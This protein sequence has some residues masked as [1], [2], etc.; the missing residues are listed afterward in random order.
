M[1]NLG[2][3]RTGVD[4]LDH[5]GVDCF[6]RKGTTDLLAESADWT[7]VAVWEH[8]QLSPNL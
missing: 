3:Q 2:N 4:R 6:H 5:V 8:L 7:A 1:L